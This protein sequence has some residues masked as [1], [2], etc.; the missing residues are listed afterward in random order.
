V[1]LKHSHLLTE[2]EFYF[3]IDDFQR[4][5][6]MDKTDFQIRPNSLKQSSIIRGPHS[7]V[8]DVMMLVSLMIDPSSWKLKKNPVYL[9][10][11]NTLS[12]ELV[13]VTYSVSSL[14]EVTDLVVSS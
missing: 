8:W 9:P 5:I 6:K 11:D 10:V 2:P 12:C 4:K 3:D 14:P 13:T 7:Q 1:L